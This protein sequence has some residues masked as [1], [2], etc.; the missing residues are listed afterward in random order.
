MQPIIAYYWVH[1]IGLIFYCDVCFITFV[2]CSCAFQRK[3]KRTQVRGGRFMLGDEG[4]ASRAKAK[5][6]S[7][8]LRQPCSSSFSIILIITIINTIT[9]QLIREGS[10]YQIG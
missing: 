3:F 1:R 7:P 6:A 5:A 2:Q 9:P 4:D 10:R 8:N